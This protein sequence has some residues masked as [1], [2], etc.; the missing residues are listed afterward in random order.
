MMSISDLNEKSKSIK[1]I[2]AGLDAGIN[3]INTVDFYGS[4]NSEI[5]IGE[6]LKGH[7]REK[8]FVALKYGVLTDPSGRLYGL[9][10]NPL[11]IKNYIVYSLKRLNLDYIDLYQPAR[12]DLGILIEE[13]I[14]AISELVKE[15]Y[16]KI[17]DFHK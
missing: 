4:G 2:H 17:L 9:D 6:A 7:N 5:I 10:M 12:I 13:T 11:K 1:A 8:A 16:I 15:G 3:L 14:G